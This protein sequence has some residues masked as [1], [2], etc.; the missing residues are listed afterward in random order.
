MKKTLLI[1]FNVLKAETKELN[2]LLDKYET[3]PTKQIER[4]IKI[5]EG[6]IKAHIKG[7]VELLNFYSKK[8]VVNG[9][10]SLSMI[11]KLNL[12]RQSLD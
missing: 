10:A 1:S 5:L 3:K 7:S 11:E 6:L 4:R 9:D 8:Q 2:G 12:I